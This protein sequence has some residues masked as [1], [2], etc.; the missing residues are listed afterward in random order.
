M[1]KHA[2]TLFT[3]PARALLTFV[4]DHHHRAEDPQPLYEA[5]PTV[6]T[7]GRRFSLSHR[8]IAL[9]NESMVSS[10]LVL[11]PRDPAQCLKHALASHHPVQTVNDCPDTLTDGGVEHPEHPHASHTT[12][13]AVPVQA[14]NYRWP[15]E[16]LLRVLGALAGRSLGVTHGPLAR[17]KCS[18]S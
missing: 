17:K 15:S 4:V 8:A 18:Q 9:T 1:R 13:T 12:P 7:R 11:G 3:L 6:G 16:A 10:G 14:L 2:E 5:E